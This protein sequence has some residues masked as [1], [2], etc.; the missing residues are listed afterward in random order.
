MGYANEHEFNEMDAR[1]REREDRVK[2]IRAAKLARTAAFTPGPWG[3]TESSGYVWG[4]DEDTKICMISFI[5]KQRDAMDANAHL[6]AAAPE[7]LEI[8]Q[9]LYN[10]YEL[11]DAGPHAGSLLFE[12][13]ITLQAHLAAAIHKAKGGL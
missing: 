10:W 11:S 9:A 8:I 7:M 12:D 3:Y 4:A 2:D 5:P 13:D 1:E 6:I